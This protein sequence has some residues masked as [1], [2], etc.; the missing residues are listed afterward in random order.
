MGIAVNEVQTVI[1]CAIPTHEIQAAGRAESDTFTITEH[2][3]N[4]RLLAPLPL[5][6]NTDVGRTVCIRGENV[7]IDGST[8]IG[9]WGE[10]KQRDCIGIIKSVEAKPNGRVLLEDGQVADASNKQ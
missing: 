2:V 5:F 10:A 4:L 6:K 7:S 3:D 8:R 9:A 1:V